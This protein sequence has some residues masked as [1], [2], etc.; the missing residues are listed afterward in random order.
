MYAPT[1]DSDE[2]DKDSF[3]DLIAAEYDKLPKY[4]TVILLGDFNAKVG[5]E[6]YLKPVAGKYSNM[7]NVMRMVGE[8]FNML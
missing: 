4:D 2:V 5:K 3:Y 1:E 8:W 7:K 6:T